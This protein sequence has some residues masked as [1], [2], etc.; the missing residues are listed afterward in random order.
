MRWVIAVLAALAVWMAFMLY[1]FRPLPD[2]LLF[3]GFFLAIGI[4]NVAFTRRPGGNSLPK[5]KPVRLS[6]PVSGRALG[7]RAFRSC[8]SES[9]SS[10]Q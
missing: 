2:Q 10:S 8:V 1:V 5:R 9:A 3:G 4:A 6:W 7:R